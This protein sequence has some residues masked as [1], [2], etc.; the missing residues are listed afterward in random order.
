MGGP[1][2]PLFVLLCYFTIVHQGQ[3]FV[4]TPLGPSRGHHRGRGHHH[5]YFDLKYLPQKPLFGYFMVIYNLAMAGL[6]AWI[7]FELVYCALKRRYNFLC[8]TVYPGTDDPY[9]T[10]VRRLKGVIFILKKKLTPFLGHR[11][12]KPSGGTL[13]LKVLNFSTPSLSFS[14]ASR[15]SKLLKA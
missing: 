6:N 14:S 3:T 10:R 7:A 11:S 8:Q 15:L 12:P 9:E 1:C 2:T 4:Q 13:L 5:N